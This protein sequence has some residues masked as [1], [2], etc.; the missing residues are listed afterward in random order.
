MAAPLTE[1]GA[2]PTNTPVEGPVSSSR[3]SSL[4]PLLV[5]MD[6]STV[7]AANGLVFA[8]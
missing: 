7:S 4:S 1:E 6:T 8:S 3:T 2:T 5:V